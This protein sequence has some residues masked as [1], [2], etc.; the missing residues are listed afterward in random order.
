MFLLRKFVL[1]RAIFFMKDFTNEGGTLPIV[2]G[3]ERVFVRRFFMFA[4]VSL[5]LSGVIALTMALGGV[6]FLATI[7]GRFF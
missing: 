4:S 2:E 7:P 6:A 5:S 1:G 3:L